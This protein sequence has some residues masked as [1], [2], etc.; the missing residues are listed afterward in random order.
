MTH[1]QNNLAVSR[2]FA[3]HHGLACPSGRDHHGG[4]VPRQGVSI[5]LFKGGPVTE[6]GTFE[7]WLPKSFQ[8]VGSTCVHSKA[9]LLWQFSSMFLKIRQENSDD[10]FDKAA[11][12]KVRLRFTW[13]QILF[14]FHALHQWFH[15]QG[16]GRDD[17]KWHIF[18]LTWDLSRAMHHGAF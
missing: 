1:V 4:V 9:W 14:Q 13:I 16:G 3:S 5:D 15:S 10:Q 17:G 8:K 6:F 18:G 7:L 12:A 11:T 2:P